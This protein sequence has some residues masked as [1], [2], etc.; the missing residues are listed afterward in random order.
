MASPELRKQNLIVLLQG[1]G[2]KSALARILHAKPPHVSAMLNG[3]KSLDKELCHGMAR[4]LGLPDDWFETPR[5]TADIPAATLQRLASLRDAAANA[6]TAGGSSDTAEAAP[7]PKADS[8][9]SPAGTPA[10]AEPGEP[11]AVLDGTAEGDAAA[12]AVPIKQTRRRERNA[13]QHGSSQ[14]VEPTGLVG[15]PSSARTTAPLQADSPAPAE[16]EV[17]PAAPEAAPALRTAVMAPPAPVSV[18]APVQALAPATVHQATL[19]TADFTP[20]Y[21]QP[22]V[23]EGGLAPITEAL[24]KILVLKARQG[25]LSEDKAF[26]LLGAVR[27]L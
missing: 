16:P 2:A 20:V 17:Q 1:K 27:L 22:L 8:G 26:E 18:E 21:S 7:V 12:Q 14:L 15:E 25:A 19:R 24:I 13:S 11:R 23:I 9:T 4:A 10:A 6:D 5:T 3:R